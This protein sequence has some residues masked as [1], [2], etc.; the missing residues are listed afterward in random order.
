[1]TVADF[2]SRSSAIDRAASQQGINLADP[3][4]TFTLW[5]E[6]PRGSGEYCLHGKAA[7]LVEAMGLAQAKEA[8]ICRTDIGRVQL[9]VRKDQQWLYS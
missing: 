6:N 5:I 7:S 2:T 8:I 3:S 9:I 4:N 1:M